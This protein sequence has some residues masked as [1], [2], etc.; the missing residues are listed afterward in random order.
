M[1]YVIIGNGI[2]GNTAAEKLRDLDPRAD[3]TMVSDEAQSFYTACALPHYLSGDIKRNALFVKRRRDYQR[4]RIK[5]VFGRRVLALNT[6]DKKVVFDGDALDYDR[7]VLAIGA[8]PLV[9]PIEGAKL[10]GVCTFKYIADALQIVRHIPKTAVVVGSGPIGT[11]VAIALRKKGAKVYIIELLARMMP[12]LFDDRPASLLSGILAAHDIEVSTGERAVRIIGGESVEG[13]V[14]DKRS[15]SCDLVVMAAGMR[16]NSEI[17]REAGISVAARGGIIVDREMRTSSSDIF[18]CG[19]CVEAAD[20]ITG[21]PSMIQLWHNAKDQAIVA[22]SNAA[23][24]QCS[25]SGSINITSLDVFGNHAVSFGTVQ[26]DLAGQAGIEVIDKAH[27]ENGYHRLVLDHGR[28]VGAQFVGDLEDMGAV[29][30][31]LI[32]RDRLQD[33]VEFGQDLSA[34]SIIQHNYRFPRFLAARKRALAT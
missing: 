22:A 33:L 26:A 14:T 17:A 13:I 6:V 32:R 15:M 30:F 31:S 21:A 24:R 9:P 2:A 7:L 27:G 23:G 8:R 4:D 18:A 3:I 11:E 10:P 25:Y 34:P 12:R 20:L 1:R 16:P 5:V 28:I 19:D 29:L